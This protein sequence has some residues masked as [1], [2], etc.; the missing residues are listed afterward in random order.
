MTGRYPDEAT[1]LLITASTLMAAVLVT[2]DQTIAAIAL[3]Q[4]QS[5]MSA[6][7]DQ[8]VWVLTSYIIAMAIATPLSGWLAE[9][10]GRGLVMKGAVLGFTLASLGCGLSTSLSEIVLFRFVQGACG[11][12]MI[13][14][15]QATLLDINPPERHAKAMAWFGIGTTIGPLA[16]PTLG[17]WLTDA[18]SWR[19]IFLIN[20]PVGLLALAGFVAARHREPPNPDTPRFDWMGFIL[21]SVCL[22]A[23]Q[24]ML[25]RGQEKDWL[26][27]IEIC[28]ELGLVLVTGYMFVVH[29]MTVR[30]PFVD[31]AIFRDRNFL[32]GSMLAFMLGFL[33]FASVPIFTTM[34]QQLL[35]YPALLTGELALPRAFGTLVFMLVVTRIIGRV[36]SR[37]MMAGGLLG[38]AIGLYMLSGFSLESDPRGVMI[39][40]FVQGMSGA[41]IFSPLTYMVFSTLQPRFRNAGTTVFALTRNIGFSV[42]LSIIAVMLSR[43]SS[44]ARARL[45]EGVRPDNPVLDFR[46]PDFDFGLAGS[47]AGMERQVMR[48]AMM[49]AYVDVFWLMFVLSLTIIPLVMMLRT[50]ARRAMTEPLPVIE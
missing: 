18:I 16:G 38:S 10:F 2:L 43:N 47:L 46:L 37:L 20:L 8:L 25:D 23:L 45:V 22:T 40:G 27:S 15:S 19:W 39:V 41:F 4:I 32:F 44:T 26:S 34:Q 24:L 31:P 14:L 17:G 11:A 33:L 21:L 6:S 48:Q 35:G 7:Q 42:G 9:R 5:S 29:V 36:D 50:P 28:V 12:G 30:N 49:T 1:R 3:P 13:P